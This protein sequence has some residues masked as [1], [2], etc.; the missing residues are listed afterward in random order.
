MY[1]LNDEINKRMQ[2][3]S[4]SEEIA[5]KVISEKTRRT[6]RKLTFTGS[7]FIIFFVF[8]VIGFNISQTRSGGTSWDN[9]IMSAVIESTNTAIPQDLEE[10]ISYSFNGQ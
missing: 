8:F 7:L 9:Y 5:R 10:F 4:W 1:N 3:K 6:K 2:Q